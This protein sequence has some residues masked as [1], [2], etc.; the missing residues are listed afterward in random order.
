MYSVR[1]AGFGREQRQLTGSSFVLGMTED[2]GTVGYPPRPT[3][4]LALP[5]NTDRGEIKRR[6]RNSDN[7]ESKIV[8]LFEFLIKPAF[9]HHKLQTKPQIYAT[10]IAIPSPVGHLYMVM[11]HLECRL[12]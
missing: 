2:R 4:S 9:K 1:F 6:K 3:L 8:F 7:I 11:S 5:A 12:F 10:V